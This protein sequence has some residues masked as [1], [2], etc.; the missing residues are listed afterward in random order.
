MSSPFHAPRRARNFKWII[1]MPARTISKG[2]KLLYSGIT[3]GLLLL[4]FELISRAYYY[5]RLSPHP[6]AMV[7]LVRDVRDRVEQKFAKDTLTPHLQHNHYLARPSFS[8]ED[9][10]EVNSEHKEANQAVYEPW[11]EFAFRDIR[12]KYV[13]V[14]DHIRRSVPER[15]DA[16]P[17]GPGFINAPASDSFLLEFLSSAPQQ[18]SSASTNNPFTIFFSR[19]LHHVWIQCYRC[20]N[21]PIFFCQSLSGEIST[22]PSYPGGQLGNAFLLQLPGADPADRPDLPG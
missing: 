19:R 17:P 3:I 14:Q 18:Q 9:N 8:D 2:K 16:P 12:S 7:Q 13:N 11:V 1:Y 4:I 15:S 20:R 22:G 5:Q 21:H 10:N 6:S